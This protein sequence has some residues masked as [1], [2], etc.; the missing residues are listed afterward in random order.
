[1]ASRRAALVRETHGG[2]AGAGEALGSRWARP[3]H[4]RRGPN[5]GGIGVRP[6]RR[7]AHSGR[8][9]PRSRHRDNRRRCRSWW[10]RRQSRRGL[11]GGRMPERMSVICQCWPAVEVSRPKAWRR[12]ARAVAQAVD[13]PPLARPA[14]RADQIAQG[15][16]GAAEADGKAGRLARGGAAPA[17]CRHCAGAR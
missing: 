3:R 5:S 6:P 16:A 9:S 15:D 4:S 10:R 12:R 8:H 13:L 17:T 2:E 11:C 14:Y 7:P 1:M